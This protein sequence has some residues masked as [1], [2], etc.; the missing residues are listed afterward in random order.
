VWRD[1][2]NAD[3]LARSGLEAMAQHPLFR[4]VGLDRTYYAPLT[5]S[6]VASY[7]SQLDT[8]RTHADKLPRFYV[9]S[10][11]WDEITTA[12]FPKHPR[13]GARAGERNPSFLDA[14]RF[15]SEIWAHHREPRFDAH[16]G[17]LLVEL[18]PMPRGAL[19]PRELVSRVESFL[20]RMPAG[21]R[22]AFELRNEEL[23]SARFAS[24]LHARGA[25]LV[26]NQWTAMPT[27]RE[28][29]RVAGAPSA[30]GFVVARLMLPRFMRYASKR[31]EY[32]P[33]DRIVSEDREMRDDVMRLLR[34]AAAAGCKDVFVLVNNKA[35]GSA[36][37]TVRAI[38]HR[39]V[40]QGL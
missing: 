31:A 2:V 39:V 38:A 5:S 22:F 9:L 7:S 14:E 25:S 13:Y 16:A 26:F 15:A 40:R 12:V 6:D 3:V 4:C 28:Q 19:D 23:L 11:V 36:P 32:A 37:L 21:P 20:D 34:A 33:F 10:K 17:P 24:M 29:L 30:G 35:E 1:A 18:T 8:A 27:I